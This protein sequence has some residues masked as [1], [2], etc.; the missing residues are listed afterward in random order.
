MFFAIKDAIRR[1]RVERGHTPVFDLTSPATGERIR[2]ACEDQF[3]D[4][5]RPSL[6]SR[7]RGIGN[8]FRYMRNYSNIDPLK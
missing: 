5:V 1:A 2:M 4:M 8:S 7:V 6:G 3:T